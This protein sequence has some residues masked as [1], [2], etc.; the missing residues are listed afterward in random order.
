MTLF[1]WDELLILSRRDLA[2]II[3]LAYAQTKVYNE[4][5]SKTM[6]KTLNIHHI[7]R[8]IFN[9]DCFELTKHAGLVCHYK[10][11]EPQSY[12]RNKEFLFYNVPARQKVVYLK[13]LS[14]RRLTDSSNSIPKEYFDNVKPNIFLKI[15]DDRIYF[16]LENLS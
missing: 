4:L 15:T 16:P 10:T 6:L 12:F 11:K 7:P 1:N 5:S 9:R 2:A 3:C 13:A 14:L 8:H